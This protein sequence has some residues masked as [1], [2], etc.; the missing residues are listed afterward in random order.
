MSS[1]ADGLTI[2]A[3]REAHERI[4][5]F[6]RRT[7]TL[8]FAHDSLGA[9][10]SAWLK[11]ELFQPTGSF[12]VRGVF[13]MMLQLPASQLERGVVSMSA[14]NHAVALAL[15]AH[16]LGV[17]AV[18]VMPTGASRSKVDAARAL[19][20]EII[21]TD[22]P[23]E[24]KMDE[25]LEE[26]QLTLVHPFDDLQVVLGAATTGVELVEDAPALDAV[27][28]PVGGGGLIGG[29][30]FAVKAVSPS[31]R[32][33]GVE[34]VGADAMHRAIASNGERE[35]FAQ[36]SIADGLKAPYAGD[37][38]LAIARECVDEMVYV[39]EAEIADALRIT[40]R[41]A[42]LACEPSAAA[43]LAAAIGMAGRLPG[44]SIGIVVSGGNVDGAVVADLIERIVSRPFSTNHARPIVVE[45]IDSTAVPHKG[46]PNTCEPRQLESCSWP[47]SPASS[48][49]RA[50]AADGTGNAAGNET[51]ERSFTSASTSS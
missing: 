11:A 37:L 32:V 39:E 23:L 36:T 44:E 28:V 10:G 16:S 50:A 5:P 20:A 18:I 17:P 38:P 24:Q 49:S 3:V 42:K 14:G 2:E 7:P 22:D 33:I 15:G 48:A 51:P 6:V 34:P 27:F 45:H 47:P 41:T 43:G 26:R 8:P 30:A 19:G 9:G 21:L 4:A 35:P 31:T 12:K 13:N 46:V 1:I 40:Y 25:V 29:V